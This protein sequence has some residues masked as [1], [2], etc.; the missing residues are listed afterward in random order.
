MTTDVVKQRSII[1]PRCIKIYHDQSVP[2]LIELLLK[3]AVVFNDY[4]VSVITNGSH[5][6]VFLSGVIKINLDRMMDYGW[7]FSRHQTLRISSWKTVFLAVQNG[8]KGGK[9]QKNDFPLRMGN[10]EPAVFRWISSGSYSK[11][12]CWRHKQ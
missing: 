11:T 8:I 3:L 12:S 5:I 4:G 6:V 2:S 1:L 9:P 10:R 7:E